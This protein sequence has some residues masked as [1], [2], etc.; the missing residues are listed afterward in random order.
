M[1]WSQT[2]A[3]RFVPLLAR[4]ILCAAF[5]PVGW[6]HTFSQTNYSIAQT[7][8]LAA[9]GVSEGGIDWKRVQSTGFAAQTG[10]VSA[11][12]EPTSPL[13]SRSLYAIALTS[14]QAG[15]PY[16]AIAA[17]LVALAELGGSIL[18]LAGAYA[19]LSALALSAVM[20][21]AFIMTTLPTLTVAGWWS[22]PMDEYQRVYTQVGL[23]A[24]SLTVAL[25]GGGAL[26]M[27]GA[28][29]SPSKAKPKGSSASR[30]RGAPATKDPK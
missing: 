24:L 21:G 25:V 11:A 29:F 18:L 13:T 23:F 26:C 1:T 2:C 4:V 5:L 9:L 6:S 27:D 12:D 17:W 28:L 14:H 22:M 3:T 8:Q 30:D 20:A 15:F 7:R 19:R 16:P 10:A